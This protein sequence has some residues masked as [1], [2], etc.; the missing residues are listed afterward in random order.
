LDPWTAS[1]PGPARLIAVVPE[2]VLQIIQHSIENG[3]SWIAGVSLDF[4][5]RVINT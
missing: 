3:P 4:L 1:R 5:F 2:R